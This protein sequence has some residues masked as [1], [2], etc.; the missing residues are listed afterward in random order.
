MAFQVNAAEMYQDEKVEYSGTQFE[1]K[2][3]MIQWD[4][5]LATGIAIFP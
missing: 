1:I 5:I 3:P 2:Y 4:R